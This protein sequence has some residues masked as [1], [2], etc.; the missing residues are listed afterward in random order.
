MSAGNSIKAMPVITVDTST[1]NDATYTEVTSGGLPFPIDILRFTSS[2]ARN[3]LLSFD[4]VTNHD[5]IVG[6]S[7]NYTI[8]PQ[9]FA[10][11][12]GYK[13][14]FS[15]GTKI[16]LKLTSAPGVGDINIIG[17]YQR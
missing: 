10:S 17:Y 3:V 11:P 16:F 8:T 9:L 4:G 13:A 2:N 15:K 12:S 5:V 7:G 14:S 1:L 6:L